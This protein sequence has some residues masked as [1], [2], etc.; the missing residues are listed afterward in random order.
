MGDL[1][2]ALELG[3]G[4]QEQALCG[5]LVDA[6]FFVAGHPNGVTQGATTACR[7]RLVRVVGGPVE[8]LLATHPWYVATFIPAG[9]YA[10]NADAVPTIAT[11]AVLLASADLPEALAH[12]IVKAVFENFADFGRLHLVLSALTPAG[13]VP[14]GEVPLHPG[15]LGYLRA[16]GLVP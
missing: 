4:D 10:G 7:A 12:A 14:A 6:V 1:G 13:M 5:N 8:Q 11:Q 16:A 3:P 2:P 9:M 15:A